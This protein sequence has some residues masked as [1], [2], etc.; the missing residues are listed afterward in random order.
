MKKINLS[1]L[2][3]E[4]IIGVLVQVVVLI[5]SILQIAGHNVLPITNEQIAE[6]VSGVALVIVTLYNTYKNRNISTASQLAQGV[7]DALKAG[8]LTA[9][10][11]IE[12]I[13]AIKQSR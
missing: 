2:T 13:E 8:E 1:G 3:T 6:I 12:I 11:A 9:A 10:E 5:N 4:A 7:T